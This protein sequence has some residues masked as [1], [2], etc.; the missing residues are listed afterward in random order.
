MKNPSMKSKL[1]Y[2]TIHSYHK[3]QSDMLN[4][5]SKKVKKGG[6]LVY[7]T[8]SIT[9]EENEDVIW[10]FLNLNQNFELKH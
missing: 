9:R 10:K 8:C 4:A 1:S 6:F 7:S 3:L 2:Q 5:S